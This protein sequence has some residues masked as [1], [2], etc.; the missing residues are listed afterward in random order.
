M[1]DWTIRSWDLDSEHTYVLYSP[2]ARKSENVGG[3]IEVHIALTP[4]KPWIFFAGHRRLSVNGRLSSAL[5]SV[6]HVEVVSF[7]NATLLIYI[8]LLAWCLK[9]K[10]RFNRV[11]AV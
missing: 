3:S 1:K 7:F 8:Q 5:Y 10:K 9:F 2:S 6:A 11:C 4:L